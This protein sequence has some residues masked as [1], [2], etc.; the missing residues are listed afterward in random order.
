MVGTRAPRRK[1]SAAAGCVGAWGIGKTNGTGKTNGIGETK[2]EET[3]IGE[4]KGVWGSG[5]GG[6]GWP[7][8]EQGP[9]ISALIASGERAG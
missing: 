7:R 1:E 4:T 9:D 2:I 8:G 6:G 3:R 5:V